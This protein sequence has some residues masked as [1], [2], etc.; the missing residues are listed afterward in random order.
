[1]D[2]IFI[3]YRIRNWFKTNIT[4]ITTTTTIIN[5]ED[6]NDPTDQPASQ[7]HPMQYVYRTIINDR[8]HGVIS[9]Y[10]TILSLRSSFSAFHF[11]FF[12]FTSIFIAER[13]PYRYMEWIWIHWNDDEMKWD[14]PGKKTVP[15]NRG[16]HENREW[17][18]YLRKR[19]FED[20]VFISLILIVR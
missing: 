14:E 12:F 15:L 7:H 9:L 17:N 8:L 18:L 20:K 1:M 6:N 4:T 19:Q 2:K 5:E 11:P 3:Q 13:K 16:R 10:N